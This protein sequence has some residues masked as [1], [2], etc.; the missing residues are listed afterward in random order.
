M[1]H[2]K[3]KNDNY[4]FNYDLERMKQAVES[5]TIYLPRGLKEEGEILEWLLNY[6][7]EK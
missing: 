4:K 7:K 6:E 5:E 1:N 2:Y 3:I